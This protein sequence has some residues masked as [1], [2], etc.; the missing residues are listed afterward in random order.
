MLLAA[1]DD[2]NR[3]TYDFLYL[4]IDFKVKTTSVGCVF[5]SLTSFDQNSMSFLYFFF[6]CAEQMQCGLCI[7]QHGVS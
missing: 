6:L 3:G 7:Y 2:K 5:E 1:I 4:P